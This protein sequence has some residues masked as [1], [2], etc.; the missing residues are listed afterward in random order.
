MTSLSVQEKLAAI[1]FA[2]GELSRDSEAEK[3]VD[4]EKTLLEGLISVPFMND[5][6]RF[7]TV[8]MS[9]IDDF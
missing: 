6:G 9:W 4:I 8:L 3:F 7:L 5:K 1:G 2:L